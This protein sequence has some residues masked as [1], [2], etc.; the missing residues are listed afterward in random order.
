MM[1]HA[2]REGLQ[3]HGVTLNSDVL[4]E[5]VVP[6]LRSLSA[7]GRPRLTSQTRLHWLPASQSFSRGIDGAFR[8]SDRQEGIFARVT[9]RGSWFRRPGCKPF[10]RSPTGRPGHGRRPCSRRSPGTPPTSL[11]RTPSV[12]CS[13]PGRRDRGT[14]TAL[15]ELRFVM[16][17]QHLPRDAP[18]QRGA[19]CNCS[20]G[21]RP[22]ISD[23]CL[24]LVGRRPAGAA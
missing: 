21:G 22:R 3:A 4:R 1:F 5:L 7:M 24:E 18:R 19:Q 23:V 14:V 15:G 11:C 9:V 16:R 20:P 13:P 2:R 17:V 8:Q 10:A 12:R 6:V